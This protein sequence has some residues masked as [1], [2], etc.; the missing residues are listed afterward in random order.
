MTSKPIEEQDRINKAKLCNGYSI[1]KAEVELSKIL[2]NTIP[3]FSLRKNKKTYL[4]D[5]QY[6]NKIIEYY[7]DYW[8]CNPLKYDTDYYHVYKKKITTEVWKFDFDKVNFAI[9][10]GYSVLIIWE[11]DYKKDY[12][13]TIKKCKDFLYNE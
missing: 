8:H 13:N 9:S 10:Q 6:K 11:T 7:G 12:I 4:Y 1:S 3:Q 2:K 5:L